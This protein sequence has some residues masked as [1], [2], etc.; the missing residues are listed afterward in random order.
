MSRMRFL[1]VV[2]LA[3]GLLS[4]VAARCA[5]A[6]LSIVSQSV[7]VDRSDKEVLFSLVFNQAPNFT[8]TDSYGRPE[9]SF[10][11]EIIPNTSQSIDSFPFLSVATV[12]RGDEIGSGSV[13]PIRYGFGHGSDPSPASGG[14][15]PI[16]ATVPFTLTG[17]KM[18]WDAPFDVLGTTNGQFAY[19]VF[20]TNFGATVSSVESVSIPLPAAFPVGLITLALMGAIVFFFKRAI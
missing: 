7:A 4:S 3:I 16:I 13:M 9:D 8:T 11:Y 2:A 1:I 18:S 15:G 19:R 12:I 6:A 5:S 20:T 17:S 14:W 10:Q